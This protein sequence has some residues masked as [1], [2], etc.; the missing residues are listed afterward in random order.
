MDTASRIPPA[1]AHRLRRR[2][3]AALAVVLLAA[4]PAACG[5]SPE[6]APSSA[7]SSAQHTLPK[8]VTATATE[9]TAPVSLTIDGATAPIDAVATTPEG[10]L[11]PPEDVARLGWWVDSSL[12][13]SGAGVIVVTGHVNDLKQGDGYAA[14]FPKL[15]PGS[16]VTLTTKAGVQKKYAVT[17]VKSFRKADEF[18]ADELNR[19]TGPEEL[20][21]VTCGGRFVGPPL[22]YESNDIAYA[23]PA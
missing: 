3:A 17:K 4:V 12:V 10:A 6:P 23:S 16:T 7:S 14:R 2:V 15:T 9:S 18:P 8:P 11:P 5:S 22:G 1:N 19:T 21:L 20:I 13:G